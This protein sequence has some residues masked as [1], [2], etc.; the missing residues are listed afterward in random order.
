MEIHQVI[1]S[2]SPGD[3]ITTLALETRALLRRIGPS[4]IFA[5][6]LDHRLEGEVLPVSCYPSRRS[7]RYGQDLLIYH[8]SIGEPE[9]VSF[10]LDRPERLILVYHNITPAPFFTAYDPAFARLLALGRSELVLLRERV[11]LALAVSEFNAAELEALDYRNVHVSPPILTLGEMCRVQPHPATQQLL[12]SRG[13]GPLMLFVGQLLPHKRPDILLQAYCILATYLMPEARI[14]LV[15]SARLLGY[16]Q[17]LQGFLRQANL[18]DA[19]LCGSL[20]LAELVAFYRSASLFVT[21]SEHEGFCIPLLEA[22]GFGLPVVARD[23]A[24]IPETLDGA[25]F[26]LPKGTGPVLLAEAMAEV[27]EDAGLRNDLVAR[28]TER[29]RAFDANGARATFLKHLAAVV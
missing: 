27:I 8:A 19:W 25:G 13:P 24:A 28:G 23:Y 12:E 2:A 14:A 29:L 18:P 22:M 5:R 4:E 21:A 10:L 16:Y 11:I 6:Y 1:V 26:L 7:A 20:D 15:G 17:A 9:L 3:A